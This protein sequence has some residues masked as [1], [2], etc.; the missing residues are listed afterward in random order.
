MPDLNDQ[1]F[2][3][4][5]QLMDTRSGDFPAATMH[6]V[7]NHGYSAERRV[8]EGTPGSY[9]WDRLRA[10]VGKNGVKSPI[11]I[12][13]D[14]QTGRPVVTDGHHRAMMAIEQGHLFVP[15]KHYDEPADYWA[16]SGNKN[17]R[18]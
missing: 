5:T 16:G 4:I 10:D 18:W 14:E 15:V 12:A 7:F 1:Q 13:H 8:T 6:G 17:D 2:T 9:D 11:R 3:P